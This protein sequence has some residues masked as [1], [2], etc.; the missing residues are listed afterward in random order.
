M[1]QY[2]AFLRAI[3]VAG[4]A[5]IIMEDLCRAFTAAGCRN[6][7]TFIQS[8]NVIFESPATEPAAIA[9]KIGRELRKI[10]GEE[11]GIL[12]RS[13]AAVQSL[14]RSRV[15]NHVE[16]GA[17]VKLYV[18]FLS[19]APRI[20]PQFPLISTKEA[21][22]IIGMNGLDVFVVSHPKKKGFFGFPNAVV[23]KE[24][25]VAATSRNWTTV[26]KIAELIQSATP[27]PG[28]RPARRT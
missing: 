17:K 23:E 19:A 4:H 7:R 26:R 28:A 9:K 16:A 5:R 10:L 15:F 20:T 1:T 8:G 14:A 21:V 12:L 3:N 6:I 18:V 13:V 22:E 2:I 11:P 25:G 27:A 24:F